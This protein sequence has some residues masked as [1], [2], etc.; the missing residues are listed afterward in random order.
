MKNKFLK[1]IFVLFFPFPILFGST[2]S[3][4][5]SI[6]RF[7]KN[8][9]INIY[10]KEIKKLFYVDNKRAEELSKLSL[11]LAEELNDDSLIVYSQYFLGLSYYFQDY[12][13]LSAEYYEKALNNDWINSNLVLKSAIAN[14][15]GIA[16]E[17]LTEYDKATKFYLQALKISNQMGDSL[18]IARANMNLG[19][20]YIETKDFEKA[21]H[22]FEQ[23]LPVLI[24]FNDKRNVANCY[25][26]LGIAN[27][28]LGNND[29]GKENYLKSLKYAGE[30]NDSVQ[31]SN[32][33]FDYAG[34]L[35]NAG[36]N[37]EALN[38]YKKS[39]AYLKNE[40]KNA[41]YFYVIQ[42]IGESYF[43]RNNVKLAEKYLLESERALEK[44]DSKKWLS[45]NEL[46]L[47]KLYAKTGNWKKFNHHLELYNSLQTQI[48]KKEEFRSL[49]EMHVRY[50]TDL[51]DKEISLQRVEIESQNQKLFFF[52]GIFVMLIIIIAIL[53]L[54]N[55]KIKERNKELLNKNIE[56]SERWK[57][58]QTCYLNYDYS[59]D[60]SGESSLFARI[61]KLLNEER[62]FTK[63]DLT[64]ED[65]AKKMGT[66]IKYVSSAIKAASE[67]NFNTFINT[68]RVEEA[69]LL[70]SDN[71][72]INWKIEAISEE[73]GFNNSTTFYQT[74]KK[75]TGL[76]PASYRKMVA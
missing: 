53:W 65:I 74:F 46:I 55:R 2:D 42:K 18:M 15:L 27:Y 48:L 64:V 52:S 39:L 19:L 62:V 14:N 35:L 57:K 31:I 51:K 44:F 34:S 8:E 20:L 37:R 71:N 41:S 16:Y 29:K 60:E 69:K 5:N 58:M 63:K 54:M 6:K 32:I 50:D 72:R 1:Y 47:T 70:L 66:N 59:K 36:S 76:T 73:C 21:V 13:K 49:A 17:F 45:D 43:K 9:Q 40:D 25:Q 30:I 24:K 61:T 56:L 28:I 26:N 22:E 10:H 67:M 68:Y 75:I 11:D 12:W 38:L 7:D 4:V 33:Y 3:L 23:S